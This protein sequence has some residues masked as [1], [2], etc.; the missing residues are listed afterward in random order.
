MG[1]LTIA[2]AADMTLSGSFNQSVGLVQ[3][4]GNITTSGQNILFGGGVTLTGD[5][6]LDTGGMSG[7]INFTG[8]VNGG[9]NL[10]LNGGSIAFFQAVGGTP[11]VSLEASAAGIIDIYGNQTVSSGPMLYTGEVV[12][13]GN[14][15]TLTDSGMNGMEFSLPSGSS[16]TNAISGNTNLTLSASSSSIAVNGGIDLSGSGGVTGKNLTATAGTSFSATGEINLSGSDG[17]AGFAG[18]NLTAMAATAITLEGQVIAL[19]GEGTAGTG[20]VGGG[21]TLTSSAGSVS[22]HDIDISGGEGTTIG[23]N[24]GSLMVTAT[25][26]VTLEGQAISL[27]G[28]GTAGT[29]G[30]G[31]DATL[32][33]SAGSVSVHNINVSGGNGTTI[34]GNGG[35]I[36]LQ[37]A[38]GYSGGYPI[39]LIVLNSD[40]SSGGDGNLV[41][42]PG[43]GATSGSIFLSSNRTSP[44]TVATIVS[45]SSGNDVSIIAPNIAMGAN[46]AMTILGN[47]EFIGNSITLGDTVALETLSIIGNTVNLLT[48]G[49]YLILDNQG[50]LYIT[51]TLHFLGGSGYLQ[52]GTL[53]PSGPLN[54]QNLGLAP[55]TFRPLLFFSGHILNYDTSSPPPPPPPPPPPSPTPPLPITTTPESRAFARYQLGIAD[56]QLSDLLPIYSFPFAPIHYAE[57]EPF[58]VGKDSPFLKILP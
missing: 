15:I 43:V 28:E 34:G 18:G 14:S 21:V 25:M 47:L 55:S 27:G 19:G 5:V 40:L 23:G 9:F 22:T 38:S 6:T 20:G 50:I 3:T 10:V 44:S 4:A 35:N 1:L 17:A 30:I 48:H 12:L 31:G 8:T 57:I 49:S 54:A 46:E 11:L 56:A 26:D 29:G 41:S 32:T 45:S 42:Q 7:A 37:A 13:H 52:V 16:A 53:V 33:S 36:T 2:A 24:G 39:G 51:P 58:R